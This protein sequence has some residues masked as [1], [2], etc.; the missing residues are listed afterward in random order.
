M[1]LLSGLCWLSGPLVKIYFPH[2][3]RFSHHHPDPSLYPL[4]ITSGI[5]YL[6]A[7]TVTFLGIRR[8]PEGKT[9]PII[10]TLFGPQ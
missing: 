2:V 7:A 1:C 3:L 8:N 4:Q 6:V 9:S 5:I 10:Q